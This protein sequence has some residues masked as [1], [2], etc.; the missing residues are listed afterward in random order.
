MEAKYIVKWR[1]YMFSTA[2]ICDTASGRFVLSF[3]NK[4]EKQRTILKWKECMFSP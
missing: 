4:K 3:G 2:K 1:K